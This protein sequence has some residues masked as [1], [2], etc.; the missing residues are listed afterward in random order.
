M[1]SIK[2]IACREKDKFQQLI[3][4]TKFE[5][6]KEYEIRSDEKVLGKEKVNKF[7]IR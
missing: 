2:K 1:E 3:K 5:E 7:T 4:K 6:N